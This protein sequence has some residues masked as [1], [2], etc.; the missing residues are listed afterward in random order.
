MPLLDRAEAA[1]WELVHA[2]VGYPEGV[3]AARAAARLGVPLILTEHATFLASLFAAPIVRERYREAV[4]AAARVVA[5][6]RMLANELVIAFPELRDRVVVIPNTVDVASFGGGSPADRVPGELLWVGNR[7]ET[8]DMPTLLRAFAIVHRERPETVLRLIGRSFRPEHETAWQRLAGELGVEAA[9]SFEPPVDRAGVAAAMRRADLFVHPSTRE[10]FGVVAVEALA[11]G[12]PVVATDSGG[13]TEVLGDEPER[14]GALVAASDPGALAAAIVGALDR[15]SSFDPA[16][17]RAHSPR[18]ASAPPGSLRIVDLYEAVLAERAKPAA[19]TRLRRG[20]DP[21][22]PA[23]PPGRTIVVGFS[24]AEFDRS[25][26]RFP[27]WVFESIELVTCG[28]PIA[29][30][31]GVHLATDGTESRVA[32]VLEWGAGPASP[33]RRM[34]RRARRIGRRLSAIAGRG[35]PADGVLAELART[36]AAVLPPSA[37]PDAPL[38][39]CLGGIDHLVAAPFV[40]AG[41]AVPAPGG[42]RWLADARAQTASAADQRPSTS[43]SSDA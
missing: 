8:K 29:G 22:V 35:D 36:L 25:I 6:S 3:A 21:D 15:R 34:A 9:T 17:L 43:P 28:P 33:V 16:A 7:T 38:V 4:A 13:V 41:R 14:F 18:R 42:L 23:A 1:T 24:R 19:A 11:S 5:V 27:A 10:T 32:D 39:V 40:A 37:G 20:G 2:H 26:A 12:L 31:A 30:R